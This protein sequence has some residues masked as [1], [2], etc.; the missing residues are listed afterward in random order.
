MSKKSGTERKRASKEK[1]PRKGRVAPRQQQEAEAREAY[2]KWKQSKYANGI[3]IHDLMKAHK[4]NGNF[5]D[6]VVIVGNR[7]IDYRRSFDITL[8]DEGTLGV[9]GI[10]LVHK[11]KL[12]NIIGEKAAAQLWHPIFGRII[13]LPPATKPTQK[14]N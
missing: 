12:K 14:A 8:D 10:A 11:R 1:K 7:L 13:D 4:V 9:D 5:K 2:E 3:M 6:Y